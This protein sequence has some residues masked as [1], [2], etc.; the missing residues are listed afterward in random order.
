M[1]LS[2]FLRQTAALV[3][4][5]LSRIEAPGL[6]TSSTDSPTIVNQCC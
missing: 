1:S 3:S 2:D 6:G 5:L 4:A